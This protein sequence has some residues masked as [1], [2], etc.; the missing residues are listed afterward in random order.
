MFWCV[1]A[2]FQFSAAFNCL[3]SNE[4]LKLKFRKLH[5]TVVNSVNPANIIDFL[6]QEAV[7]GSEDVSALLKS[8]DEPKRQCRDLLNQLHES[9]N[10]QAFVQLYAA[11]KVESHLQWLIERIDNFTDQPLIDLLQQRYISEPTGVCVFHRR[12]CALGF[13]IKNF[14]MPLSTRE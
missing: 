2:N 3:E 9:E 6:F 11:I 12:K 5:M 7:I 8:K 14:I 1:L 13:G 4:V 10:P